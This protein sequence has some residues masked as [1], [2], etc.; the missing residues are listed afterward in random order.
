MDM[1]VGCRYFYIVTFTFDCDFAITDLQDH[2]T[3]NM[4]N[5]KLC[6]TTT[7]IHKMLMWVFSNLALNQTETCDHFKLFKNGQTTSVDN[8]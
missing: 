8:V 5:F 3:C 1:F 2:F 7:E 4:F 6:K